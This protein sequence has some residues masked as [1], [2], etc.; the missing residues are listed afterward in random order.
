MHT[1]TL[2]KFT[3]NATFKRKKFFCVRKYYELNAIVKCGRYK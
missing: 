1:S 2:Q 3:L